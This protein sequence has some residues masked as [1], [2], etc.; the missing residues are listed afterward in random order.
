MKPCL[1]QQQKAKQ[2]AAAAA[3]PATST[4]SQVSSFTQLHHA[5]SNAASERDSDEVSSKASH[6]R[7]ALPGSEAL[8]AL[9]HAAST[10]AAEQDGVLMQSAQPM[11]VC[12][13]HNVV[14]T[15]R[16]YACVSV[17]ARACSPLACSQ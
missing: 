9:Q 2:H 10:A 11:Q 7:P 1:Q 12:V 5:H 3:A 15:H 4:S 13:V 17:L 14:I 16:A 8:Q 6:H